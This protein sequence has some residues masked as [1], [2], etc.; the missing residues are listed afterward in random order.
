MF[1]DSCNGGGAFANM[2]AS[3][4]G[5][6]ASGAAGGAA[7]DPSVTVVASGAVGPYDYEVIKVN[8]DLETR[9]R[10]DRLA[11]DQ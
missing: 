11:Q 10:R 7:K 6:T 5:A 8:A 9:R 3:A 1:D 4:P 2:S